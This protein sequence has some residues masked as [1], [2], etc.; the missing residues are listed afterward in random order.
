V[1][2]PIRKHRWPM[3]LYGDRGTSRQVRVD[4]ARVVRVVLEDPGGAGGVRRCRMAWAVAGGV[5]AGAVRR[6]SADLAA[7]VALENGWRG[8]GLGKPG[9][10]GGVGKPGWRRQGL[11]KPVGRRRGVGKRGGGAGSAS[12]APGGGASTPGPATAYRAERIASESQLFPS[13]AS[14]RSAFNS[15]WIWW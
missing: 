2:T 15:R 4:V 1:A 9:G 5:V 7:Q 8:Q 11:G 3:H 12:G 14:S 10:A 13:G 6:V